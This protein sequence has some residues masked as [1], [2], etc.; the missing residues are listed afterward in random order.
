MEKLEVFFAHNIHS[1]VLQ[2]NEH[3]EKNLIKHQTVHF[4]YKWISF[5][6]IEELQL[7]E[8]NTKKNILNKWKILKQE[9]MS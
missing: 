5:V 7:T 2:L 9:K 1:L 6:Y 4:K 3:I 8:R